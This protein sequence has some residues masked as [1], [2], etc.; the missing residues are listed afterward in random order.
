M[1][2]MGDE[3]IYEV[4]KQCHQGLLTLLEKVSC[5]PGVEPRFHG[6]RFHEVALKLP[7]TAKKVLA[8]MAEQGI[9]GGYDLGRFSEDLENCVLVNVTETKT[10][11]DIE[12]FVTCLA[13]VLEV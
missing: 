8:G 13:T 3:G 12:K 4:A 1:S 11:G 7:S 2:L 6:A 5:L 10:A 9:L